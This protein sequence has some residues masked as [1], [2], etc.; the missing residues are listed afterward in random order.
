MMLWVANEKCTL[1]NFVFSY[2][3]KYSIEYLEFVFKLNQMLCVANEKCT[4]SNCYES[5]H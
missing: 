1:P 5:K 2:M 3:M 4:F